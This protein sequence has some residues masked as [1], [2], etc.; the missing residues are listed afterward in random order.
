ML[1]RSIRIRHSQPTHDATR[2]VNACMH[3]RT[4]DGIA[5]SALTDGLQPSCHE[6]LY[7]HND[8]SYHDEEGASMDVDART[9]SLVVVILR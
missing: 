5:V 4:N 1:L 8:V 9:R 6:A 7:F 3:T 2:D